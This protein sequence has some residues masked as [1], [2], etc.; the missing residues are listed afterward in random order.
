MRFKFRNINIIYDT[1]ESLENII[2]DIKNEHM[3]VY[4]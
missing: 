4:V 3:N 1:S 2:N